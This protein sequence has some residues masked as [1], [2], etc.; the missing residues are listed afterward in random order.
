MVF[1]VFLSLLVEL[2]VPW[3]FL[4]TLVLI[5]VCPHFLYRMGLVRPHLLSLFLLLLG[6]YALFT[7]RWVLLFTVS[8][9]YPL[10]YTAFH[11]LPILLLMVIGGWHMFGR[12]WS[13]RPLLV[14]L[15][16]VTLGCLLHPP[17][18]P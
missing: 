16:G 10:C 17:H 2:Q 11:T 5:G 9:C 14:S 7:E 1:L 3:P 4:W 6:L 13:L 18:A 15:V 8:V 12:P